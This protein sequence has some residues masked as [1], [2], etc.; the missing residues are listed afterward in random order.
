MA[1]L[2]KATPDVY[3]TLQSR[4]PRLAVL[5]R[6][7]QLSKH[8]GQVQAIA[9]ALALS[10]FVVRFLLEPAAPGLLGDCIKAGAVLGA[11]AVLILAGVCL[12]SYARKRGG[13]VRFDQPDE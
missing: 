11:G 7:G 6:I 3:R 12:K 1:G 13:L 10:W 4:S 2:D 8:F 5:W 9:A